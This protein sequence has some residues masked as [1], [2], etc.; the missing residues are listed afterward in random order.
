MA[1]RDTTIQPLTPEQLAQINRLATVARCVSAL[2]HEL[3]NSLQ[4]MGGLIELLAERDDLPQDAILRI[5]RIGSYAD[6][7]GDKIRQVV[8]Y[9]RAPAELHARVDLSAIV[10]RAVALRSY[11]LE[12]AGIRIVREVPAERFTVRGSARD[13]E[14]AVLNLL[15]NAQEAIA[16]SETREL[17]IEMTRTAGRVRLCV[18]D[19]GPGVLPELRDRIFEPFFTTHASSGAVG[20]G[21]SVAAHTAAAHAGGLSLANEGP[22]AMFVLDLPE[23]AEQDS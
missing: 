15:A 8:S 22:G 20:L 19:T 1:E 12:R 7:A 4:V 11:E 16:A 5:E 14:Q 2:A 6:Q 21:L 17:L 18:T 23:E 3:N 10:D 9:V 13:L